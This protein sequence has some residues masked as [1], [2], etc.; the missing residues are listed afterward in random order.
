[1]NEEIQTLIEQGLRAQLKISSLITGALFIDLVD[2]SDDEGL[3]FSEGNIP[4][5]PTITGQHKE[6]TDQIT[7]ITSKIGKLPISEIGSE[8]Q[9]SLEAIH[10]MLKKVEENK[11]TDQFVEMMSEFK[12]ASGKLTETLENANKL[13]MTT[14][15]TVSPNGEL[16]YELLR[17]LEDIRKAA[18]SIDTLSTTLHEKPESV[19]FGKGN[20][21]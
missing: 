19:I 4:S 15:N 2:A 3:I 11:T 14:E 21:R 6:L 13:L 12:H 9:A 7:Q 17:M 20:E 18:R 16:H 5:I 1:M 10:S 8:L